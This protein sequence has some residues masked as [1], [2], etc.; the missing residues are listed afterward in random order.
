MNDYAILKLTEE[1]KTTN[2]FLPLCADLSDIKTA[3]VNIFGYPEQPTNY[4]PV[5]EEGTNW[6]A[7]QFGLTKTGQ[8]LKISNSKANLIH[9]IS[10]KKGQSG[11]PIIMEDRQGKLL[12]VGIHTGSVNKQSLHVQA[13]NAGRI[14][15]PGLMATLQ[16]EA[17]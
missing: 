14:V 16:K 11:A 10:T 6:K 4:L 3:K 5:D 13:A 17:E 9:M 2:N 8:V 12:I 1:V 7:Y 15:T